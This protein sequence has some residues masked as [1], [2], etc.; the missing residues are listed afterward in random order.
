VKPAWKYVLVAAVACAALA[1]LSAAQRWYYRHYVWP[2]EIQQQLLGGQLAPSSSLVEYDGYSH[3]GQGAFRWR[4][5]VEQQSKL[6]GTLCGDQRVDQCVFHRTRML[7]DDVTQSVSYERG[8][9]T[10]EEDW[11]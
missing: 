10:V 11:S 9:L 8:V 7:S 6:L 1:G 4:Y 3:Y 2:R 5:K